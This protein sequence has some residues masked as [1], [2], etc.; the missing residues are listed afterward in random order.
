MNK[1]I[2]AARDENM[3]RFKEELAE[4]MRLITIREESE[5]EKFF[6]K[7]MKEWDIKSPADLSDEDKKKFFDEVEKDW[8]G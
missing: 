2:E 5:Y 1:L 6:K 8:K 3:Y 4:A 7:K